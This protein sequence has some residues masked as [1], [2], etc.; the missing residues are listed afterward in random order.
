M[1]VQTDAFLVQNWTFLV[2][3]KVDWW[4]RNFRVRNNIVN[5]FTADCIEQ[6][7]CPPWVIANS[8][9][10]LRKRVVIGKAKGIVSNSEKKL[11]WGII[12]LRISC[13]GNN[14]DS[15]KNTH[16][17]V[18]Y[19]L[20]NLWNFIRMAYGRL[21]RVIVLQQ[22]H[23]KWGVTLGAGK[24]CRHISILYLSCDW[25]ENDFVDIPRWEG[26]STLGIFDTCSLWLLPLWVEVWLALCGQSG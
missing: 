8:T 15:E 6:L 11:R 26:M 25:A 3:E 13:Q 24:Y 9:C 17:G 19:H 12:I 4:N 10:K 14:N 5:K 20:N 7:V 22:P 16:V 21:S 1:T 23:R 18:D 2:Y